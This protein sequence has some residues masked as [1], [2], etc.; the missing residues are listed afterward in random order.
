MVVGATSHTIQDNFGMV[1]QIHRYQIDI[2]QQQKAEHDFH[3][4]EYIDCIV[5]CRPNQVSRVGQWR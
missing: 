1:A 4:P 2:R 5:H 3:R